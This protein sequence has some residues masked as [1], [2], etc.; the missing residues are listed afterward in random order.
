MRAIGIS[1]WRATESATWRAAVRETG[2]VTGR[3]SRRATGRTITIRIA[4]GIRRRRA[5]VQ[6]T[7]FWGRGFMVWFFCLPITELLKEELFP[8]FT[9]VEVFFLFPLTC[10]NWT[11]TVI[12]FPLPF[13]H[14][15]HPSSRIV[16]R[17]AF[18]LQ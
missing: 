8:N 3:A 2:R 15:L 14:R 7:H 13:T 4:A 10:W 11:C 17:S 9:T 12:F 6:R 5:T 1:T 18:L 16:H